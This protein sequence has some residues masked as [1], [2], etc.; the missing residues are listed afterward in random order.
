MVVRADREQGRVRIAVKDF[1]SGIPPHQMER[2]FEMFHRMEQGNTRVHYGL[3]VGL[4][5]ARR[6][7]EAHGGTLTVQSTP[8]AGSTFLV[9]LPFARH[10][11]D[12]L[13]R[14]EGGV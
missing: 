7:V 5:I 1:G 4:F 13:K 8:G 6:I 3:G 2:I 10:F 14:R 12:D 9:C 11:F